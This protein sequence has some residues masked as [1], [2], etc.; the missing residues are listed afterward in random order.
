MVSDRQVRRPPR[1]ES[2]GIEGGAGIAVDKYGGSTID[3]T[4]NVLALVDAQAKFQEKIDAA[5]ARYVTLETTWILK[6]FESLMIAER[7]RID[8]LALLKK[9]YDKAISET[10]TGQMKTTSDLVSTQL[11]KVT[12]SLSDT[13]NKTA[14]NI[15]ATLATMDKRLAGVEQFRYESGGKTS[16]SDPA[17]TRIAADIA[18]LKMSQGR[19]A[20]A[21]DAVT[22]AQLAEA[23]KLQRDAVQHSSNQN[24]IAIAAAGIAILGVVFAVAGWL[25]TSNATSLN[26]SR[27]QQRTA[28]M[29]ID[30]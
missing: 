1:G 6:H 13:I 5:A 21:G 28:Y 3:P 24:T 15:A 4:E 8:D 14:D 2:S 7:R 16:V 12:T 23:L 22:S 20:G 9:D 29:M 10:Q 18:E 30:V 19:A 26:S 25:Y 27:I 11:D 17:M